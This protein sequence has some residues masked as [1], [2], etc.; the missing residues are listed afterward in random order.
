MPV[1]FFYKYYSE[2]ELKM[3]INLQP[4]VAQ[5]KDGLYAVTYASLVAPLNVQEAAFAAHDLHTVSP[6]E[7]GYLRANIRDSPFMPYSRTDMDI[8]YDSRDGGKVVLARGRALGQLFLSDLVNAHRKGKEFIIPENER[9]LVYGTVDAM[10][11]NGRAFAT[12][13]GEHTIDASR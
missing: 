9:E 5:T 10:L 6:A 13:H 2:R 12:K 7:L 1:F 8:F 4:Q 11:K 3:N